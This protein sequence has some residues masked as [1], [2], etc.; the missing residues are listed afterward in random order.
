LS[1]DIDHVLEQMVAGIHRTEP[2]PERSSN[3]Q[4]PSKTVHW[5]TK[6]TNPSFWRSLQ[7]R[8]DE[9]NRI[10]DPD[11]DLLDKA[12]QGIHRDREGYRWQFCTECRKVKREDEMTEMKCSTG[13]CSECFKK[14]NGR[15]NS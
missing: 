3:S 10:Y 11:I 8:E 9:F 6:S 15:A 4:T 12:F 1:I 14:M 5:A 2:L 13:V 7:V